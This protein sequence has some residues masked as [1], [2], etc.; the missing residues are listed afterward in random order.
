MIFTARVKEGLRQLIRSRIL[1]LALLT[2]ALSSVCM[3]MQ[4]AALAADLPIPSVQLGMGSSHNPKQVAV[5]LQILMLMT[6]LTLAPSIIIMTTAFTR[7]VIVFSILRSALGTPQIPPNQVLIGL[8]L[9]LTLFIMQPT[10]RAIDNTAYEPYMHKQIGFS[11]A[12]DRAETPLRSFMIRQTYKSDL[13]FFI[14]IS[15]SPMP[16]TADNV[17]MV[18]LVPAFLTSEMK[19]AFIIGFYIYLPFMVIDLV[20]ASTL[21]S[22]GMMMLPP[23]VVSLPAKLLLFVLANGWALLIGSLV[24][25]FR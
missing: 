17:S 19:T 2:L 6:V 25:G 18:T 14:S 4:H 13:T 15:H 12:L 24:R 5:T 21:M 3:L 22:M 10:L 8:A 7:I 1:R 11:T 16:K 20:V 23:V 9:F